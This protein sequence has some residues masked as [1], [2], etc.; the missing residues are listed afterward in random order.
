MI[1]SGPQ[2]KLFG[3]GR[4]TTNEFE[5]GAL[6]NPAAPPS[7]ESYCI[8]VLFLN[9]GQQRQVEHGS[10]DS[11]QFVLLTPHSRG[12]VLLAPP[13]PEDTFEFSANFPGH[14]RDLDAKIDG[15]RF[16]QHTLETRPLFCGR[17]ERTRDAAV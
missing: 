17:P 6:A 1:C 10:G 9:E 8:P 16:F 4:I 11:I 3:T 12:V 7:R 13:S 14:W 5:A 2:F 15:R